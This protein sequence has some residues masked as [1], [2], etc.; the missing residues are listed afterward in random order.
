MSERTIEVKGR[1]TPRNG[2]PKIFAWNPDGE[3]LGTVIFIHGLFDDAESAWNGTLGKHTSNKLYKRPDG[4]PLKQ[5]FEESGVKAL[6][7]VPEAEINSVSFKEVVWRSLPDLLSTAGAKGPVVA[8]SHSGGYSTVYFWLDQKELVHISLIDSMYGDPGNSI[9]TKYA[10]WLRKE[11]HTIDLVGATPP[12][13]SHFAEMVK[14]WPNDKVEDRTP[15]LFKNG[16]GP[17]PL[18]AKVLWMKDAYN[19][20]DLIAKGKVIP[21]LLKRAEA[22]LLRASNK[23]PARPAAPKP[24]PKLFEAG[25]GD[26]ETQ[27]AV[28]P[29]LR[30]ELKGVRDLE[31]MATLHDLVLKKGTTRPEAVKAIQKALNKVMGS[32]LSASGNYDGDTEKA[33]RDFQTRWNSRGND[34]RLGVDGRVGAHTL[35]ALDHALVDP[36]SAAAAAPAPAPAPGPTSTPTTAPAP[37]APDATNHGPSAAGHY[38]LDTTGAQ[39]IATKYGNIFLFTKATTVTNQKKRP[40]FFHPKG[41]MVEYTGPGSTKYSKEHRWIHPV[42]VQPLTQLMTTLTEEGERIDDESMKRAVIGSA[43]RSWEQ[44]GEGFLNQLRKR[45]GKNPQIFGDLKFPADLEE[46]AKSNLYGKVDDFINHLAAHHPW[47]HELAAKLYNIATQFK[48]PGGLSPHESGLVVDI[49]FPYAKADKS[50][51][52]HAITTENNDGARLSGAGMWLAKYAKDEFNF[53]SYNTAAEIWHM[54]WLAWKDT[55]A[56][57]DHKKS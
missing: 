9:E 13:R 33:V 48:A 21:A 49:D 35:L 18:S 3:L 8:V 39:R 20:M 2:V 12:P 57:P 6:F 36:S 55:D 15:P 14:A 40:K 5:Q 7:L 19:H 27:H 22:A 34:P 51:K 30:S 42:L 41:I 50:A 26:D 54:E 32:K 24:A 28:E 17:D 44:D 25:W 38:P 52:F 47:N 46:E 43:W 29:A 16:S 37:A 53:S 4:K 1:T 31:Q 11:G 45:I 23:A 56:D 10:S